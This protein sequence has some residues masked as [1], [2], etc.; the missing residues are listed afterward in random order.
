MNDNETRLLQM[1][2]EHEDSAKALEIAIRV[3]TE[4]VEDV[5][6]EGRHKNGEEQMR[7][8]FMV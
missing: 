8:A 5:D 1:I 6:T 3:L 2:C 4:F 7:T